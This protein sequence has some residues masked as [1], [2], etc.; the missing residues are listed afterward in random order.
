MDAF[1]WRVTEHTSTEA[2][3]RLSVFNESA[4]NLDCAL[5][6]RRSSSDEAQHFQVHAALLIRVLLS[7]HP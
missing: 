2:S 5:I 6:I 4:S 3:F 1:A 7:P